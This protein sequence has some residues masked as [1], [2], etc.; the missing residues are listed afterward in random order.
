MHPQADD[1]VLLVCQSLL[2]Q[3]IDV[4]MLVKHVEINVLL[5]DGRLLLRSVGAS[6]LIRDT[7][8]HIQLCSSML[9]VLVTSHAVP[10]LADDPSEPDGTDEYSASRAALFCCPSCCPPAGQVPI[11]IDYAI[12]G[13][14][15]K[16]A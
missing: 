10:S 13:Q 4:N 9:H 16:V 8:N 5:V 2:L 6:M 3:G 1:S 14:E 15:R 12:A 7:D 11:L